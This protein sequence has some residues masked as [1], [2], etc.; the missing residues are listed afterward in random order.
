M[1][2][3]P[4]EKQQDELNN[5]CLK[6]IEYLYE[7]GQLEDGVSVHFSADV[8]GIDYWFNFTIGMEKKMKKKKKEKDKYE[9]KGMVKRGFKGAI[10]QV[11]A[12]LLL[13]ENGLKD[14]TN[15]GLSLKEAIDIVEGSKTDD[16]IY[17]RHCTY[18]GKDMAVSLKR[19]DADQGSLYYCCEKHVKLWKDIMGK[20]NE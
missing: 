10:D 14:L 5:I 2:G 11:K 19:E 1:W 16:E 15:Q 6:T 7:N 13:T 3:N 12:N 9:L 18:C 8:D 4:M 20:K 17:T